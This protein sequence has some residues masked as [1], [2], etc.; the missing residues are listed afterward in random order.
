MA[1]ARRRRRLC[2]CSA[3]TGFESPYLAPPEKSKAPLVGAFCFSGG[4]GG[5]NHLSEKIRG[6]QK[7][8]YYL[9]LRELP[10][11]GWCEEI[12]PKPGS[13]RGP[14]CRLSNIKCKELSVAER[15]TALFVKHTRRPGK[16]ADGGNLY[17]QVRKSTRSIETDTVTK[18]WLFR[19]SRFG[20]DTWL[21]LGPYPDVTLSE[22][23]DLA[24]RERKKIRQS[25]DPLTDKRAR[26]IDTALVMR[27]LEPIW[28]TKTE[29]ASR[30]PAQKFNECVASTV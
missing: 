15:I 5:K 11:L 14:D 4:E 9:A 6:S 19:Y 3:R 30:T 26:Q 23:R 20:K 24:T 21:G 17:L 22:A 28:A 1:A 16:Y 13:D 18:S 25:I 8:F 29:T 27:C 7:L 12:Q 10:A 2:R